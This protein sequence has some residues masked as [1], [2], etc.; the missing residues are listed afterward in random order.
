MSF[1]STVFVQQGF[2]VPGE[3]FTDGPTRAEAFTINSVSAANNI[4]GATCCS[5]TS[6]GFCAAG[7]SGGLPFAG[8]LVNP[9]NQALFGSG[10]VPLAPTLTVNN[11]QAV[12]CATMGSF[13][14][15]L[16]AVAAIGDTVI[17]DNTT[18]AISTISTAPFTLPGTTVNTTTTVTM[19]STTGVFAGQPV[20]GAG[21]PANTTVVSVTANTSIVI[22]NAATASATVTLTFTPSGHN[23]PAGK[24][25]ANAVVDYYTVSAAGLAVITLT[26][27]LVIPA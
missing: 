22:S 27:A 26:P 25:F 8:L 19:A 6:Q 20:T 23:L 18:G 10:G 24:S 1:Q 14:V 7:N 11:F 2:G 12:Q 13:V 17:Y 5:V 21:I 16:P 3:Q 9:K 15:T 4:I